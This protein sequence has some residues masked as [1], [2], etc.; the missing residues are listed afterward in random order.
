M[1]LE[2]NEKKDSKI[3]LID[4]SFLTYKAFFTIPKDLSTV[5]EGYDQINTSIIFGFFSQVFSLIKKLKT[6]RCIFCWD[7][8]LSRRKNELPTYKMNRGRAKTEDERKQHEVL[9]SQVNLL[10]RKILPAFGFSNNLTL[11]GYES[12]DI[13]AVLSERLR[14]KAIIVSADNDLYQLLNYSD[15]HN[16]KEFYTFKNLEE[17]HNATPDMWPMIKAIAGC[18][19]DNVAGV[20]GVG[21]KTAVKKKKKKIPE[22][23]KSWYNITNNEEL[24]KKNLRFVRLPF[25]GCAEELSRKY[26]VIKEDIFYKENIVKVFSEYWFDSFLKNINLWFEVLEAK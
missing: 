24:I 1:R 10:R 18:D 21:I 8:R 3:L 7:S 22:K 25:D 13:L 11:P 4:S 14:N 20:D 19:S 16:T 23:S 6:N 5:T 15:I 17:E 12:D 26:P 9:F 2:L